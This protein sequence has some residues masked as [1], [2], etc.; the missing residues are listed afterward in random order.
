MGKHFSS[1]IIRSFITLGVGNLPLAPGT[2][3]SLL[4]LII[5]FLLPEGFF[6]GGLLTLILL[7]TPL[8]TW[9]ISAHLKN[10][11]VKD[12][13]YIVIDEAVGL[14]ITLLASY[15]QWPWM[16]AGF[17]LFRVLDIYKPGLIGAIDG[18]K[19]HSPFRQACLVMA[20][21]MLAGLIAASLLTLGWV[22]KV[23]WL[24]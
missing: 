14:W 12:P 8:G 19:A 2:W 6:I 22:M 11:P 10:T 15:G 20:D 9:A 7:F 5:A 1:L 17:I 16:I 3:G 18:L 4:A 24:G 21:D 13:G 23:V